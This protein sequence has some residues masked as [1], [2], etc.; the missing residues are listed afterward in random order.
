MF[1]SLMVLWR[2]SWAG[3]CVRA[4]ALS[5]KWPYGV[6]I[7]P[8]KL[9][10]IHISPH[11]LYKTNGKT[12]MRRNKTSE[13]VIRMTQNEGVSHMKQKAVTTWHYYIRRFC[14]WPVLSLY[15]HLKAYTRS[16]ISW[17]N[18]ASWIVLNQSRCNPKVVYT[19]I[20]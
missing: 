8:E 18:L 5:A 10:L 6:G 3:R 11:T 7:S 12:I 19:C 13:N 14:V 16:I 15:H 17:L 1:Q 20:Q 9:S 4:G 2:R